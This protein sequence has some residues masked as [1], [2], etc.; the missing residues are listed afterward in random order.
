[1]PGLMPEG[2]DVGCRARIGARRAWS[3]AGCALLLAALS[4]SACGMQTGEAGGEDADEALL[5]IAFEDVEARQILDLEVVARPVAA[6]QGAGLWAAVPGLARPER[7]RVSRPEGGSAV[8]V[9]L[10]RAPPGAGVSL[11]A[12]AAGALGLTGPGRVR[13]VALRPVPRLGGRA[14]E[15]P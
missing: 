12:E 1:V 13:V 4:L 5:T 6:E 2:A 15:A 3:V 9:A 10:Y 7:G 14:L 11:S 8:V